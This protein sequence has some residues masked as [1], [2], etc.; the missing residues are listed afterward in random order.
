M[1]SPGTSSQEVKGSQSIR[2][3]K[4]LLDHRPYTEEAKA[5][6][7][8]V[9]DLGN[10]EDSESKFSRKTRVGWFDHCTG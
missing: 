3:G 8:K 10:S 2:S 7:L 6:N 1:V 9:C 4:G 5:M